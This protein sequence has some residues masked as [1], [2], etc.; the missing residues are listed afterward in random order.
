MAGFQVEEE[1]ITTVGSA[2][3]VSGGLVT[4]VVEPIL[5]LRSRVD[6]MVVRNTSAILDVVEFVRQV[7]RVACT[8]VIA[9]Q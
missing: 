7:R 3:G 9:A 6:E 4:P 8:E 2:A 1:A 5:A